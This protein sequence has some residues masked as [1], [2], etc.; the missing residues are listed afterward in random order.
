MPA[1]LN[2]LHVSGRSDHGGGPE[3]IRLII[4]SPDSQVAHF[5]ACPST[6]H[7]HSIYSAALGSDRVFPIPHRRLSPTA[8]IHLGRYARRHHIDVIHS[9]GLSAGIY[10][11]LLGTLL[12]R[13]VVHTFHGLPVGRSARTMAYWG[14]EAALGQITR[15]AIAVSNGERSMARSR[16]PWYTNRIATIPNGIELDNLRASAPC[17][18][19]TGPLRL[20]SFSR[21]N[22]QKNPEL[23]STIA[24]HLV[25]AGVSFSITAYGEGLQANAGSL[26]A[27]SHL[28]S[29]RL[30]FE[31]CTD[32]PSL[33]LAQSDI[34][35]STSRWEG[36]PIAILEAWRM[37]SVVVAS[38]VVGNNDIIDNGANG[39]LFPID[40]PDLAAA[41]IASLSDSEMQRLRSNA[42]DKLRREFDRNVMYRR[43][44]SEYTK[45]AE[46]WSEGLR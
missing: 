21:N 9:H 39:L 15:T 37:G 20:I 44:E 41:S 11:R 27:R 19:G 42:N 2:I 43:L 18:R 33:A 6:G 5:I 24:D 30:R 31:A 46:E 13:P 23:L 7:Y 1:P 28:E 38:D 10:G 25:Q 29:G 35:L 14:M 34:Y 32:N 22:S 17:G 4:T 12:R 16:W 8:L 36:L 3:H 26:A 45:A 40:R